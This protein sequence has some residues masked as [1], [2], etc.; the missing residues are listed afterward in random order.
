MTGSNCTFSEEGSTVAEISCPNTERLAFMYFHSTLPSVSLNPNTRGI[1]PVPS[2]RTQET[3][4]RLPSF[5]RTPFSMAD[6]IS[7][8]PV[9]KSGSAPCNSETVSLATALSYMA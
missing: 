3:V 9:P 4:T 8:D 7:S 6:T 1:S 5:S 2:G